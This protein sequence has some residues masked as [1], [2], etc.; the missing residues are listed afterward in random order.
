[1]GSPC[2][3]TAFT[4]GETTLEIICNIP[5]N[6]ANANKAVAVAGDHFPEIHFAG[7]GYALRDGS[8]TATSLV[9]VVSL[10]DVTGAPSGGTILTIPGYNFG[11][12]L[13]DSYGTGVTIGGQACVL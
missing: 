13:T 3:I 8:L 4:A 9:P 12:S 5:V 6:A 2:S 7:V 10:G 1:M 11:F